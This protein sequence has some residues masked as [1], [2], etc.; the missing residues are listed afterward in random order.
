MT[1]APIPNLSAVTDERAGRSREYEMIQSL[2]PGQDDP[3]GRKVETIIIKTESFGVWLTSPD[4]EVWW[5]TDGRL[6]DLPKG[7]GEITSKVAL[8]EAI[9]IGALDEGLR[10]AFRCLVGEGVARALEGDIKG[11]KG[12][13][14][15]SEAYVLARLRERAR[16]WHLLTA[17]PAALVVVFAALL[18]SIY[19][20]C[21]SLSLCGA[22]SPTPFYMSCMGVLGAAFSLISRTGKLSV[23]P[24]AGFALHVLE[25]VARLTVGATAGFLLFWAVQSGFVLPQ[26]KDQV[27][28]LLLFAFAGGA[29]ERLIPNLV[30]SLE[31][32]AELTPGRGSPEADRKPIEAQEPDA[33][34]TK[35]RT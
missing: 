35:G 29:S 19:E 21:G 11:A 34:S 1:D 18:T 12:T 20:Q 28:G 24:A 22:I 4:F 7:F 15:Y 2:T 23:D 33:D 32:G 6:D 10:R 30:S 16:L 13:L 25:I 9:Q 31:A 8:L 5:M 26:F 27:G 17:M 14:A 3:H